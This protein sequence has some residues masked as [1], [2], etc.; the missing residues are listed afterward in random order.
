MRLLLSK[1]EVKNI[2][3]VEKEQLEAI[4]DPFD[5]KVAGAFIAGL[6]YALDE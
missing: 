1:D 5:R 6:E 3:H 2:I 4:V